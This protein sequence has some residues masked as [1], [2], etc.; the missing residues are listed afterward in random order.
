[1]YDVVCL[2]HLDKYPNRHQITSIQ[3]EINEN[4]DYHDTK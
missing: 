2:V 1:M 4:R 3:V